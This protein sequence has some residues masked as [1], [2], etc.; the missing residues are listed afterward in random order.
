MECNNCGRQFDKAANLHRHTNRKTPCRPPTYT[1]DGCGKNYASYQ[2]L[3]QHK[4]KR[5]RQAATVQTNETET[6]AEDSQQEAESSFRVEASQL[7]SPI[8][9]H[10]PRKDIA[11]LRR[12][13]DTYRKRCSDLEAIDTKA[14]DRILELEAGDKVRIDQL[15]RLESKLLA[16]EVERNEAR[17]NLETSEERCGFLYASYAQEKSN[18][19]VA[20]AEV[21]KL[22]YDLA[23]A[24]GT[25]LILEEERNKQGEYGRKQHKSKK[26]NKQQPSRQTKPRPK[27]K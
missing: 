18:A 27:P 9:T 15:N 14:Q 19:E 17:K 8:P 2:S 12:E 16:I 11:N 26:N 13:L 21:D 4:T 5:C 3:W 23:E 7:I 20:Q 22:R 1:C 24:Q 6:K 25:R 10:K